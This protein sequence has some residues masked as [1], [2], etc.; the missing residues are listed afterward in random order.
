M[1]PAR[2]GDRSL[3]VRRSLDT[4]EDDL[5]DAITSFAV[6]QDLEL[7]R[8]YEDGLLFRRTKDSHGPHVFDRADALRVHIDPTPGGIDVEFV[9][10]LRGSRRK[11]AER[12]RGRV[13]RNIGIAGLFAFVGVRGLVDVVSVGDFVLFGL[14][15]MF[16][17]R[18]AREATGGD[19]DLDELERTIANALNELCDDA[20]R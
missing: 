1:L 3:T 5:I 6:A 8:R 11:T 7:D 15:A 19:D 13:V 16:G 17:T 14:S 12:R 4:S 9:A 18:A 2:G 10:D 20:E